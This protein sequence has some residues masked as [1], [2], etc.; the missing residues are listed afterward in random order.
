MRWVACAEN[1]YRGWAHASRLSHRHRTADAIR[2][3]FIA[4]GEHHAAIASWPDQ[5]WPATQRRITELLNRRV[6]GIHIG[7]SDNPIPSPL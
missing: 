4:G 3:G 2:A 1:N 7:V 6:E 5:H